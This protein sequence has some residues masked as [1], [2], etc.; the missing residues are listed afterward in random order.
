MYKVRWVDL[1]GREIQIWGRHDQD[2]K[3]LH[4]YV[5]VLPLNR[6]DNVDPNIQAFLKGGGSLI[7]GL[8]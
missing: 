1:P 4:T 8:H 6:H 2:H 5:P 3:P 7:T